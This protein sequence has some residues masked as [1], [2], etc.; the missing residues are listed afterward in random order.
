MTH[1][2]LRAALSES[3]IRPNIV[4]EL[5]SRE[6]VCEAAA[7]GIGIGLIWE[8]EARGSTKFAT[9]AIPRCQYL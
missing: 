4:L 3:G 2:L 5:G 1:R 8:L 7:A 9:L 6:A